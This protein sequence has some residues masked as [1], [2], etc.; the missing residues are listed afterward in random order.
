MSFTEF[1]L[2]PTL[3]Q[4]IAEQGFTEPTPIQASALP[5]ALAGR[6]VLA[7]AMTGSGKTAAFVLP[8]LERLR[9]TPGGGATRALILTPTRELALQVEE[10]LRAL[11][12]HAGVRSGTVIGGVNPRPQE[13]ILR[14]GVDV[15]VATPGRL[16]D[17]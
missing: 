9:A 7:C 14:A 13:R 5:P 2:H 16:L 4:G 8:L 17:H 3:L 15:V 12:R 6:D 1:K 10:H 11:G